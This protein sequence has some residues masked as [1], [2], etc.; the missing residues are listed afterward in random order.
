MLQAE[1][2]AF[3]GYSAGEHLL[4]CTEPRQAPM[5]SLRILWRRCSEEPDNSAAWE[6][7]LTFAQQ[8]ILRIAGRVAIM[9]G[10]RDWADIEDIFQEICLKISRQSVKL[11]SYVLDDDAG[12]EAYLTVVAV[13]AARDIMRLRF[14][15]K[16]GA[17]VTDAIEDHA[18]ELTAALEDED[19]S[20]QVLLGELDDLLEATP[21]DRSIFWLY[22]RQGFTVDEISRIPA[23]G[24]GHKG[25]GS[26]L[27]RMTHTLRERVRTRRANSGGGS[28]A[29]GG[30]RS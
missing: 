23:M 1:I 27:R 20:R 3:N 16:R 24:L 9:S 8:K 30:A 15:E 7:F 5:H 26:L 29:E 12:A 10:I 22:Y 25:V 21:R 2:F 14:A 11:P 28:G 17:R 19:L 18:G 6:E 4:E 13:N